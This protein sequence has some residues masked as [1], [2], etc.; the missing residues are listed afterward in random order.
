MVLNWN[1]NIE[2][3]IQVIEKQSR[4]YKKM[5]LEIS[6]N[7]NWYY[8]F[9]MISAIVI[10]PLPGLVTTFGTLF[11]DDLNDMVYYNSVASVLS[12]LTT[13]LVS[14]IKFNK[15]D[16]ISHAHKSAS[17]KYVS[18][19]QNIK[20]QLMLSRSDRIVA[21]DY[22]NWLLQSFDNLYA[23]SPVLTCDVIHKY[24]KAVD[25]LEK[26]LETEEERMS[27]V[28]EKNEIYFQESQKKKSEEKSPMLREIKLD[29]KTNKV[30]NKKSHEFSKNFDLGKFDD[31]NMMFDI[32]SK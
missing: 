30:K 20:R 18:I 1:K 11:C 2:S 7:S 32:D 9:F 8:S 29:T 25:E 22:I 5:H 27:D 14:I 3:I 4:L 6:F 19:E 28:E 16:E 23:S 24:E 13:I 10:S 26:E 15:Y 31:V 21:K 17:F 12:F